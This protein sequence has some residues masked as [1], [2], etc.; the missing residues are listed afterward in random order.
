MTHQVKNIGDCKEVGV[1]HEHK[2]AISYPVEVKFHAQSLL[3]ATIQYKLPELPKKVLYYF[4]E[5]GTY[6][7]K[8]DLEML[9]SSKDRKPI[10]TLPSPLRVNFYLIKIKL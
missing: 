8:K 9:P 6:A 3:N 5:S 2:L 1:Y 7:E 10:R 4:T